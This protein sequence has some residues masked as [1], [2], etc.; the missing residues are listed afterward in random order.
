MITRRTGASLLAFALVIGLT[1]LVARQPV[2][3]VT[4]SPGPTIDVLGK[5]DG[6]QIIEVSRRTYDDDG[7]LRLT[8][9]VPSGPDRK[10]QIPELL[11][12]WVD[13]DRAVYPRSA[14]YAP[15]DTGESVR[16]QSGIQMASS[17]DNAVAAALTALDIEYGEAVKVALVEDGG[18]A[19]GKLEAGDLVLAVDG[20]KVATIEQLTSRIR[21]RPVG[22]TVKLR[23]RR[24]GDVLTRRIK[25]VASPQDKKNSAVLIQVAPS[26]DFPFDVDLN[27][28]ENIGGP[29]AGLMFALGIFDVLTPGSLTGGKAIAGTGEIDAQGRVGPIGGIQQKVAGAQ[30]DGA[31]LFLVPADNCKEALGANYDPDE[32]RLVKATS[33]EQAIDTLEAWVED[34]DAELPRCTR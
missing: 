9:V 27:I 30:E 31:E 32:I 11:N 3:Y 21:P 5:H 1:V 7:A 24:D 23:V 13:P 22:S 33:F 8:T 34:P 6:E 10:V 19:D 18:P 17:K 12:A 2:P 26:Y 28:S 15:E 4:Y 16:T 25:T 29:S 14:I 20:H